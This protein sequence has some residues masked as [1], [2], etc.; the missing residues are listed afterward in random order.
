[1]GQ[2]PTV[3]GWKIGNPPPL[4][5]IESV[6]CSAWTFWFETKHGH[7]TTDLLYVNKHWHSIVNYKRGG[8]ASNLKLLEIIGNMQKL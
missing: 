7:T 5:G 3:Y 4:E 1:M 8:L 2:K 6:K